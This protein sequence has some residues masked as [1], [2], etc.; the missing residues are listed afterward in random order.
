MSHSELD[1]AAEYAAKHGALSIDQKGARKL[2]VVAADGT[3]KR[4]TNAGEVLA[5]LAVAAEIE[6]VLRPGELPRDIVA[7]RKCGL[8][9]L[10][11]GC[12]SPL[13]MSAGA[14][15][16]RAPKPHT[17]WR[18]KQCAAS[19][20][21]K[22]APPAEFCSSCGRQLSDAPGTVQQ[23]KRAK[24]RG[25]FSGMCT[26]CRTGAMG[27]TIDPS[28]RSAASR[29]ARERLTKEERQAMMRR[30]QA[31]LTSDIRRACGAKKSAN[32]RHFSVSREGD[33]WVGR[34]TVSDSHRPRVKIGLIS[35]LSRSDAV[36]ELL[37]M[38]SSG[39]APKPRGS[40][41]EARC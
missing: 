15:E 2:K 30:A 36:S 11:H 10:C 26:P 7:R 29:A 28:A 41:P 19:A 8:P 4:E 35:C 17:D 20:R 5:A 33:W 12:K 23:R 9:D 27:K 3:V 37:R 1:R 39:A 24:A 40:H 34:V 21:A 22:P 38:I 13:G 6:A 16:K 31:G 25:T 14:L 18:C 32:S